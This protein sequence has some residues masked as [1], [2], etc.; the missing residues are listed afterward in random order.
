MILFLI[1]YLDMHQQRVVYYN[2]SINALNL[3]CTDTGVIFHINVNINCIW[4]TNRIR[5]N[6]LY[7]RLM[8]K[9][10]RISVLYAHGRISIPQ[11]DNPRSAGLCG[12]LTYSDR[13]L[14]CH[15]YYGTLCIV[16]HQWKPTNISKEHNGITGNGPHSHFLLEEPTS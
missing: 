12:S 6:V 8:E 13:Q 5:L 9:G 11:N 2:Q 7:T 1:P 16:I 3:R 10:T 15:I 14:S 4:I